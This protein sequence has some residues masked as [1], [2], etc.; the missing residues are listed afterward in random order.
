MHYILLY[1]QKYK[2]KKKGKDQES[3]EIP[4]LT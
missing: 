3:V 4:Q 1:L 2:S